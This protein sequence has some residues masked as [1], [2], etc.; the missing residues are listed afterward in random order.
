MLKT[1]LTLAVLAGLCW[2]QDGPTQPNDSKPPGV[3]NKLGDYKLFDGKLVIRVTE[4][5]GILD[6]RITRAFK[7][8]THTFHA[9]RQLT[10]ENAVW[11]IL[12][13]SADRVWIFWGTTLKRWE[14]LQDTDAETKTASKSY[15]GRNVITYGPKEVLDRLPKELVDKLSG[16]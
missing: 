14:C 3:I 8:G 12:P 9:P 7:T 2:I 10:K 6:Y 15:S 5:D 4:Q 1:G 16:K 13:E 11:I